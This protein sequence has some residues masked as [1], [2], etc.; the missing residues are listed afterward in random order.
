MFGDE[1]DHAEIIFNNVRVHV[2]NLL[3]KEGDGFEIAQGRL[4]PGRIHHCM[5]TIGKKTFYFYF[6]GFL[7]FFR[8]LVFPFSC[9]SFVLL[10]SFEEQFFI[11]LKGQAEMALA[12]MVHRVGIRKAFGTLLK[13]KDTIRGTQQEKRK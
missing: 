13:D 7:S 1:H 12:A 9:S 8:L 10:H 2:S 6:S 5:R 4:G 3:M 11:L